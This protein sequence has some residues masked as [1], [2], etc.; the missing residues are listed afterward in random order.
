VLDLLD[1]LRIF[2]GALPAPPSHPFALYIWEV[3][4]VGTT[5]ARRDAAFNA[6]KRV[7]ALTPDAIAHLPHARIEAI[8]T[9]AGPMRDERIRALR[10]GADV[11]RRM[12]SLLEE[13]GAGLGRA[14]RAARRIP[15][16]GRTSTLRLLLGSSSHPVLPLDE[17]ALRVAR[18]LGYGVDWPMPIRVLRTTRQAV[19]AESG[20]DIET[21]RLVSQYFTHHGLATCTQAAPHCAVC[22][23]AADCDWLQRQ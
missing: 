16:L 5:P 1:R 22:P 6:L 11:F 19:M 13:F 12:P 18:R 20:R 4:S 15:H 7:P 17:H 14:L 9:H 8:V 23:L 3:L 10:A 21:L 2:Y